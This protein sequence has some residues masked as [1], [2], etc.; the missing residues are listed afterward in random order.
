MLEF[1]DP[2]G[3]GVPVALVGQWAVNTAVSGDDNAWRLGGWLGKEKVDKR[4][5]WKLLAQYSRLE[6]DAFVDIFP[7]ADLY[8]GGTDNKGWELIAD[9]GVFDNVIFSVDY[10]FAQ[11]ITGDE[12]DEHALQTDLIFKF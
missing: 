12:Q 4:G 9:Y 2:F 7:D 5:Q 11:N 1:S 10:Y 6:A 3:I 8:D